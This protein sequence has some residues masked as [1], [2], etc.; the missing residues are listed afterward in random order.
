[1]TVPAA[2]LRELRDQTPDPATRLWADFTLAAS[3]P[4]DPAAAAALDAAARGD[5]A[6]QPL[7]RQL[8]EA[9]HAEGAE[10][11]RRLD[12]ATRWLRTHHPEAA[13]IWAGWRIEGDRLVPVSA[14][15]LH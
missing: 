4:A 10:R 8:G 5:G 3:T 15:E 9:L 7:A 12:E 11:T 6:D 13:R 1:V 14:P 2:P